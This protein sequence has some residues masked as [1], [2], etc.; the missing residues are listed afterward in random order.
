MDPITV[1]KLWLLVKP[2]RRIRN[3][4]RAK[5]GLPPLEQNEVVMAGEKSLVTMADGTEI[6]RTEPLIPARTTTK[7]AVVAL[8]MAIGIVQALQQIEFPWLWLNQLLDNDLVVQ[9]LTGAVL[10]I[11]G[12]Y[13]KTPSDVGKIL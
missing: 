2:I 3:H 4:R 1:A 5:R 8:P 7:Q 6:V 13:F 10:V 9:V 12:R 11:L